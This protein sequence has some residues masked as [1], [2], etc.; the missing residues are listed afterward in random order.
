VLTGR[1]FRLTA[2]C[3]TPP[4]TVTEDGTVY[5]I[6]IVTFF[7]ATG[8]SGPKYCERIWKTLLVGA[9]SL[10]AWIVQLRIGAE[11]VL[12]VDAAAARRTKREERDMAREGIARFLCVAFRRH[13]TARCIPLSVL[14]TG[15]YN[16]V[17]QPKAPL[18][19][20]D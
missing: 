17:V 8:G 5:S 6:H 12:V 9:Q 20:F 18:Q 7:P 13:P 15:L 11:R 14:N 4:V 2:S 10:M 1:P 16:D 19:K 3:D